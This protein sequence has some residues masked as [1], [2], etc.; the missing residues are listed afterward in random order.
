MEVNILLQHIDAFNCDHI[1]ANYIILI[2]NWHQSNITRQDESY[3]ECI[4]EMYT[5]EVFAKVNFLI[6]TFHPSAR[7]HSKHTFRIIISSILY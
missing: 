2:A 7:T 3:R 5:I 6:Q 4:I 1:S